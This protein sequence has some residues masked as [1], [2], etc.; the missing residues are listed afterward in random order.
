MLI[1]SFP[2]FQPLLSSFC[3]LCGGRALGQGL[4]GPQP[5]LLTPRACQDPTS[6]P[7]LYFP[8]L[9]LRDPPLSLQSF[10]CFLPHWKRA[11]NNVSCCQHPSPASR[12]HLCLQRATATRQVCQFYRSSV[13]SVSSP[14]TPQ[15]GM[16]EGWSF[17]WFF[18]TFKFLNNFRFRGKHAKIVQRTSVCP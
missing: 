14:L 6:C 8:A 18:D 10:C 12:K 1:F 16:R 15:T 2:S 13:S 7:P 11:R 4:P 9:V 3:F 17:S 5:A